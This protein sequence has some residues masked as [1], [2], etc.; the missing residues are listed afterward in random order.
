MWDLESTLHDKNFDKFV[1][2]KMAD[3]DSLP[4][5]IHF[6][7]GTNLTTPDN[8]EHVEGL[9]GMQLTNDNNFGHM[10]PYERRQCK[11]DNQN[12]PVSHCC[13]LLQCIRV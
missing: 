12:L 9:V 6:G 2:D 13:L 7:L 10:L 5:R 11:G 3:A 4:I 1:K 8:Q